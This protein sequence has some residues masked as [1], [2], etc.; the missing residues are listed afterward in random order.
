MYQAGACPAPKGLEADPWKRLR[1]P[2]QL[3]EPLTVSITGRTAT[4]PLPTWFTA[5]KLVACPAK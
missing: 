4:V 3:G 5:Q 1:A 2:R